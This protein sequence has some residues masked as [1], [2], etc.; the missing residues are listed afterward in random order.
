MTGVFKDKVD[1]ST[2]SRNYFLKAL[3]KNRG[4]NSDNQHWL[5]L[6]KLSGV[7]YLFL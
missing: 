4:Q 7:I 2:A 5:P 6:V 1:F 3:D